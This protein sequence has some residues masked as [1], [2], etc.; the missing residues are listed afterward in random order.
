MSLRSASDSPAAYFVLL[1]NASAHQLHTSCS[2][3]SLKPTSCALGI[4]RIITSLLRVT[5]EYFDSPAAFVLLHRKVSVHPSLL[6]VSSEFFGSS[7]W[8][9]AMKSRRLSLWQFDERTSCLFELLLCMSWKVCLR[10]IYSLAKHHQ[11]KTPG[12][13]FMF[14]LLD[15]DEGWK[16][17]CD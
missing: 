13:T 5:S 4:V 16:R 2:L 9:K 3:G 14:T 17:S 11:M 10:C 15:L 6:R 7:Q 1:R 12:M 8:K